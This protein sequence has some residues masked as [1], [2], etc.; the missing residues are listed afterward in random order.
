MVYSKCF[1]FVVCFL[2]DR[3]IWIPFELPS[4]KGGGGYCEYGIWF[5]N[6]TNRFD[7]YTNAGNYETDKR[8]GNW[9]K[10]TMDKNCI[11]GGILYYWGIYWYNENKVNYENEIRLY[12]RIGI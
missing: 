11:V 12:E 9:N 1:D 8:N 10:A 5:Y 6:S 2:W 7:G 4:G 3:F